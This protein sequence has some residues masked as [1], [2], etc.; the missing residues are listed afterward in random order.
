MWRSVKYLGRYL[1]RS[2]MAVS[3]LYHYRGGAVAHD[4]RM[5]QHKRQKEML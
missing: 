2:P 4:H 5:Q 3:Q 1:K